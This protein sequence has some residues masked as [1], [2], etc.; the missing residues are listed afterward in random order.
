M[1]T[2][3]KSILIPTDFSEL[4]ESALKVGIAIAKR[5]GAKITLLHA[6]SP[7]S[8]WPSPS[9]DTMPDFQLLSDFKL[10]IEEKLKRL[11]D[12]FETE[13]G[14]KFSSKLMEG[15]PAEMICKFAFTEDVS[16]IVMGTHG[17]SGLREFFIGSEAYRVVKNASCPV[18]TIPGNWPNTDFKKVLFPIRLV[19]EALEKYVFAKP[20]IEKNNSELILLGLTEEDKPGDLKDIALLIDQF[21]LKLYMNNIIYKTALCPCEN[22]PA[23]VMEIADECN[24]DLIILTANF[25]YD[26]RTFFVGPYVQQIVN[27][28]M[29]PVLSIKTKYIRSE[30]SDDAVNAINWGS[31]ITFSN[32]GLQ[33]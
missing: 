18:L 5:Q 11:A 10:S 23:K 9:D 29:R 14:V 22:F 20:I 1:K 26:F 7:D 3:I 13:T 15:S 8:Y 25:D 4:S 33:T 6:I 12:K 19:P 2:T 30:K 31:K 27:H 24:S 16:L 17:T 32:L 21:K 28:S